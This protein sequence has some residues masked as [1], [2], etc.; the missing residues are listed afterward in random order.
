M[1]FFLTSL[2][3]LLA[4]GITA[5]EPAS[6]EELN[7]LQGCWDGTDPNRQTEECWSSPAGGIM[8]G[9]GRTIGQDGTAGFEYLRIAEREGD[10][11]LVAQPGGG[12]ATEFTATEISGHFVRFANPDHDFPRVIEYQRSDDA[13]T[14]TIGDG[15]TIE[16]SENSVTFRF[17]LR[18]P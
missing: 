1:R 6:L 9:Y 8:L 11:I 7:W 17:E 4:I 3:L 15:L 18:Q 14:A 12:P 2:I 16:D 13:L 10:V 5:D